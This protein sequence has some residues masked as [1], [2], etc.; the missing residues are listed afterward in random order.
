MGKKALNKKALNMLAKIHG[1]ERA[2]CENCQHITHPGEGW[3]DEQTIDP[4]PKAQ[5]I[6]NQQV[7][8]LWEPR[9]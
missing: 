4:A 2:H 8:P 5:W 6:S 3:C 1:F 7:C 9:K